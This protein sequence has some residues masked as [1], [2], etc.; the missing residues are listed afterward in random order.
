M[1]GALSLV[2]EVRRNDYDERDT[3]RKIFRELA[4]KLHCREIRECAERPLEEFPEKVV[5]CENLG[6]FVRKYFAKY[7]H[8]SSIVGFQQMFRE[9][10][11]ARDQFSGAILKCA[12]NYDVEEAV[13]AAEAL[14]VREVLGPLSK[15]QKPYLDKVPTAWPNSYFRCA[16][17]VIMKHLGDVACEGPSFDRGLDLNSLDISKIGTIRRHS[18]RLAQDDILQVEKDYRNIAVEVMM[19]YVFDSLDNPDALAWTLD[20]L[21]SPAVIAYGKQYQAS[22]FYLESLRLGKREGMDPSLRVR[23]IKEEGV[24]EF[25]KRFI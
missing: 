21:R 4:I 18:L 7:G 10:G 17:R 13:G 9:F 6:L 12:I 1:G 11:Y 24:M 2:E 20:A 22:S 15:F 16:Q 23:I 5:D 25:N 3:V 8:Q 14:T 19:Q